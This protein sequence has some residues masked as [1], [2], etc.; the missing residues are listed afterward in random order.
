[1]NI[2]QGRELW[3]R[4][5]E[6]T[7]KLFSF[8]NGQA[9]MRYMLTCDLAPCSASCAPLYLPSISA[10]GS[11]LPIRWVTSACKQGPHSAG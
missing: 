7:K 10:V 3:E 4:K 5:R 11:V 2:R 9:Q 1:M 6:S 8:G